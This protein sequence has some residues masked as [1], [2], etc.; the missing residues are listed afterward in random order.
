MEY[1]NFNEAI[2]YV[3]KGNGNKVKRNK[4]PWG[5]IVKVERP[6]CRLDGKIV[7]G[8]VINGYSEYIPTKEDIRATDW[9]TI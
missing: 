6:G 7:K 5:H 2:S 3:N 4:W 9:V 8:S 1:M